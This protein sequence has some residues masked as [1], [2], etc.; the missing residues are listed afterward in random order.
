MMKHKKNG[1]FMLEV[2]FAAAIV[3]NAMMII[4]MNLNY[5]I[6]NVSFAATMSKNIEE[7][8]IVFSSYDPKIKGSNIKSELKNNLN[9]YS[10]NKIS[11]K[12]S[13]FF[14]NKTLSG[15]YS[16]K[17]DDSFF[18]NNIYF[19]PSGFMQ[20]IFEIPIEKDEKEEKDNATKKEDSSTKEEKN[21]KN[22][23]ENKK[24]INNSTNNNK[25]ELNGSNNDKKT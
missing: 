24:N 22:K 11:S 1:Y 12:E 13:L 20:I 16:L 10:K 15:I 18:K 4:F 23:M 5:L 8:I 25:K 6:K 17:K 14:S 7:S 9:I 21:K 19:R 3:S 2:M